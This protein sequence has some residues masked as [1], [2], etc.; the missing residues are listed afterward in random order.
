MYINVEESKA[1]ARLFRMIELF[2]N[3]I[4]EESILYILDALRWK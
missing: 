4:I 3:F 2:I 1:L